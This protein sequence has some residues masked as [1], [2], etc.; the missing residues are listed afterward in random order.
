MGL[1]TFASFYPGR[2][3]SPRGRLTFQYGC[4]ASVNLLFLFLV[5][6]VGYRKGLD[7]VYNRVILFF[8]WVCN[9]CRYLWVFKNCPEF[10]DNK[11]DICMS[12]KE[13]KD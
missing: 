12:M 11:C 1:F 10:S 8:L 6:D 13:M 7:N 2:I 5:N 9:F 3:R 4:F